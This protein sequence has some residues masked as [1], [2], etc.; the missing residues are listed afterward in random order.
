MLAYHL[1][2][3]CR[4]RLC[5]LPQ[6]IYGTVFLSPLYVTYQRRR[7]RNTK[8]KDQHHCQQVQLSGNSLFIFNEPIPHTL[9]NLCGSR[10]FTILP[11]SISKFQDKRGTEIK[12]KLKYFIVKTQHATHA[13]NIK[14]CMTRANVLFVRLGSITSQDPRTTVLI[15]DTGASFGLTPFKS[16]FI[17]Y[18]KYNILVKDV[19]KFNNVIGIVTKIHR[20]VD[21]NE[22]YLFLPCIYYHLPTTDVQLFSPK[23]YHPLLCAH[24]R[25]K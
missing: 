20:F 8:A 12:A 19:K 4:W 21:A 2:I 13:N 9:D 24:S 11:K 17:D 25:I 22:K 23:T 1:V 18:V 14:T 16:D 6:Q 10:Y 7:R 5:Q 3:H 15:L